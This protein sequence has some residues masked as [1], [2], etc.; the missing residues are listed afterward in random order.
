MKS[1]EIFSGAKALKW[2]E[3]FEEEGILNF[4]VECF[5]KSLRSKKIFCELKYLN[6]LTVGL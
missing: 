2:K 1:E 3:G 6:L 4:L 5:E